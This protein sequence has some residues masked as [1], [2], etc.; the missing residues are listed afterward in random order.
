MRMFIGVVDIRPKAALVEAE[1]GAAA[2]YLNKPELGRDVGVFFH[3]AVEDGA[4]VEV[5]LLDLVLGGYEKHLGLYIIAEAG[6]EFEGARDASF[7]VSDSFAPHLHLD[8]FFEVELGF[9]D[10]DPLGD[11][12]EFLV[13]HEDDI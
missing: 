10:D 11:E 2:G 3:V 9:E 1:D 13:V 8:F 7:E 6:E 12:G 5:D 4:V